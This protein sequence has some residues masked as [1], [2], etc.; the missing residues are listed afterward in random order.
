MH[1]R[2][3]RELTPRPLAWFWRG[4]LALDELTILDG[5]P[6]LGE[7]LAALCY[8]V[9]RLDAH[10]M[11][12]SRH[13]LRRESSSEQHPDAE[14]ASCSRSARPWSRLDNDSQWTPFPKNRQRFSS[15]RRPPMSDAIRHRIKAH[16]RL[17][18]D[19]SAAARPLL[20][21][22]PPPPA[23]P[24]SRLGSNHRGELK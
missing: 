4:C 15:S 14:A 20:E 17:G 23:G 7:S 18:P 6:G 11:V 5:D 8:L 10:Q 9:S 2:S 3:L 16:R 22:A 12:R 19:A 21:F 13:S 24:A 1:I